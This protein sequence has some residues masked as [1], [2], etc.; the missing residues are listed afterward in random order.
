MAHATQGPAYSGSSDN[1]KNFGMLRNE[2]WHRLDVR[3]LIQQ[4]GNGTA[5]MLL[6]LRAHF[7]AEDLWDLDDPRIRRHHAGSR[8]ERLLAKRTRSLVAELYRHN[9]AVR[10][11]AAHHPI[12]LKR[13]RVAE[14]LSAR[15]PGGVKV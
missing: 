10:Y 3:H 12:V 9:G 2:A 8:S 13:L 6:V 1:D 4:L 14:R 11:L 5:Q 7:E 15:A